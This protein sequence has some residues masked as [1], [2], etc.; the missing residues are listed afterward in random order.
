[1]TQEQK[2][3]TNALR[4]EGT[5]Y[6]T[7]AERL[8]ISINT[9]KT[10]LRRYPINTVQNRSV[11]SGSDQVCKNCGRNVHQ[12]QGHKRKTFCCD[13]C[14]QAWWNAHLYQVHRKA[15]TTFECRTCG[16]VVTAY[17]NKHR[18]YCSHEC[19]IKDRFWSTPSC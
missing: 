14:R 12:T 1:M 8:G 13:Q 11:N 3:A 6:R 4:R 18:K 15:Y 16:K 19:Y 9:V 2:N 7:I 10:H 17:G 5:S